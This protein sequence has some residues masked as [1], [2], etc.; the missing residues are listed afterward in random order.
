MLS[1]LHFDLDRTGSTP[2]AA[3]QFLDGSGRG[4]FT[5][6]LRDGFMIVD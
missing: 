1:S 5:V 2:S 3:I 4:S 6:L